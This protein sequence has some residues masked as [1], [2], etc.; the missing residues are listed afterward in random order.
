MNSS[1]VLLNAVHTVTPAP[2]PLQ[3]TQMLLGY[4]TVPVIN[5]GYHLHSSFGM[6]KSYCQPLDV[7]RM[8]NRFL[9]SGHLDRIIPGHRL[10]LT[11]LGVQELTTY[12]TALP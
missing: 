5:N 11:K 1:L 10:G 12:A 8:I 6:L 3:L 2:Y 9:R 4:P 7:M